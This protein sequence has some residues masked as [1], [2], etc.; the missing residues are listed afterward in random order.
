MQRSYFWVKHFQLGVFRRK[1]L[2]VVGRIYIIHS[3]KLDIKQFLLSHNDKS[4]FG[5]TR[6]NANI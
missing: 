3:I 5:Y 4:V 2:N 1:N 6:K